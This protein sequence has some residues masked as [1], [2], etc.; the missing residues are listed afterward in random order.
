MDQLLHDPN[1]FSEPA[2]DA[3]RNRLR[4]RRRQQRTRQLRPRDI[5]NRQHQAPVAPQNAGRQSGVAAKPEDHSP[6][7]AAIETAVRFVRN[8]VE[9]TTFQ[10]IE[11]RLSVEQKRTLNG[12][13]DVGPIR[14]S[15]LG[16]VRR[17]PR[18]CSASGIPDLIQRIEWTRERRMLVSSVDECWETGTAPPNSR[19]AAA[20]SAPTRR[21]R[22]SMTGSRT[23][24]S[25]MKHAY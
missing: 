9:R 22:S 4:E 19:S 11:D 21:S 14:G 1:P 5:Q 8:E 15:V 7:L 2:M 23:T 20:C 16:W 24:E 13:L 17:I 3:P 12:M 25:V 10:K 18:S 6:A